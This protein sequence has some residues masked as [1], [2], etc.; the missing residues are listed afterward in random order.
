[1]ITYFTYML[2]V[3]SDTSYVMRYICESSYRYV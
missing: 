1:M 2:F 3:G